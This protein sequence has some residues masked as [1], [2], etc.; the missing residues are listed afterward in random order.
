M[1]TRPLQVEGD[2]GSWR[3]ISPE[4]QLQLSL[5]FARCIRVVRQPSN[6]HKARELKEYLHS[7]TQQTQSVPILH[8]PHP[9]QATLA[10][11]R[12]RAPLTPSE[13]VV[14]VWRRAASLIGASGSS[15][16]AGR[17]KANRVPPSC[18]RITFSP[19]RT[20]IQ[21]HDDATSPISERQ[22]ICPL[23]GPYQLRCTCEAGEE[24]PDAV[25]LWH[26]IGRCLQAEST[27]A[28]CA[29]ESERKN[30]VLQHFN[31]EFLFRRC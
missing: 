31:C 11:Y 8:R 21:A 5:H 22:G 15:R 20:K 24:G 4:Q 30:V 16:A 23:L 9:R 6:L 17:T 25:G 13:R 28:A 12:G 3:E 10:K 26:G 14:S 27:R 19:H 7:Q 2:V 18:A 29:S 1:L